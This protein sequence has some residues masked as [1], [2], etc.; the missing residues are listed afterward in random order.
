MNKIDYVIVNL[1]LKICDILEKYSEKV[2]FLEIQSI[3]S[4]ITENLKEK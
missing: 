2:T 4:L 1:L 3:R